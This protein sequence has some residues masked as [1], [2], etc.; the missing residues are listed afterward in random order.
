MADRAITE[1]REAGAGEPPTKPNLVR[2]LQVGCIV[3]DRL[4]DR[5]VTNA[6]HDQRVDV[7]GALA[8]L[9]TGDV[10]GRWRRRVI[11]RCMHHGRHRK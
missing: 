6:R 9:A 5:L 11:V 10:K 2:P 1:H 4:P 7:L 8:A 3:M